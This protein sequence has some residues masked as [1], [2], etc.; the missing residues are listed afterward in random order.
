[1]LF[2]K[3]GMLPPTAE[4]SPQADPTVKNVSGFDLCRLL[5]GSLGTIGLI[6]EA[7]LRTQPL[8]E[9]QR[10][11]SARAVSPRAV[12]DGSFTA[13]SV[14]WNGDTT[15]AML[16]GLRVDTDADRAALQA[17]GDFVDVEPPDLPPHRWS[18]SP[19][20]AASFAG[21]GPFVAEIGVGIVH[22]SGPQPCQ[23][24][25]PGVAALNKRIK[26]EFDPDG[27]LNPGR[28]A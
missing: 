13:A 17:V 22:A 26:A 19:A 6:G 5:V 27:R 2:C 11:V 4:S 23:E 3:L 21:P 28:C 20:S 25:P 18:C 24:L 8:P 1:M 12:L 16:S 15:W 14:L 9:V 7:L 10:W